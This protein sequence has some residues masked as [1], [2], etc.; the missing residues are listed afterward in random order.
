[1][2]L[3]SQEK[4]HYKQTANSLQGFERRQFIARSINIFYESGLSGLAFAYREFGWSHKMAK[5][6]LAELK[7]GIRCINA[8]SFTGRKSAEDHLPNLLQD[9]K[10][11]AEQHSQTDYT[12][13]TNQLYTRLS[14][15]SIRRH[16]IEFK[17]YDEKSLPQ[18]RCIRQKLN[19][20]GFKL[21]TVSKNKP[22][23]NS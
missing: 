6:A 2:T 12:F 17:G 19:N 4:E 9:I 10:D 11:I 7:S 3:T 22:K 8:Y 18:E 1:M 5:T 13:N 16:L 15:P 14:A 20:L 21:R 23:K